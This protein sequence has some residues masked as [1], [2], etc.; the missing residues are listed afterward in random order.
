MPRARVRR[1]AAAG[2]LLP[3][4]IGAYIH[5]PLPVLDAEGVHVSGELMRSAAITAA[6]KQTH[7]HQ[8]TC[9]K[10]PQGEY[11]CRMAMPAAVRVD[12]VVYLW[13]YVAKECEMV[14]CV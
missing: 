14:S 10:P 8:K 3:P 7:S 11:G 6:A 2:A 13:K 12:I 9:K 1:S 5:T 4:P